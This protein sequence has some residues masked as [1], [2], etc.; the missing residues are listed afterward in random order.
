MYLTYF[1]YCIVYQYFFFGGKQLYKMGIRFS[2]IVGPPY[3]YYYFCEL[4][5]NCHESIKVF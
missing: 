4:M 1:E 5:V 2:P 3:F